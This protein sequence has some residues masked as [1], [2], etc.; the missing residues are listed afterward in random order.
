MATRSIISIKNEDETYD[1]VYCHFDGYPRGVGDTLN[2]SYLTEE[3]IRDLISGGAMSCLKDE[4]TDCEFYTKRGEELH[5]YKSLSLSDLKKK[6]QDV[7]CEYLYM[8]YKGEWH[9][10]EI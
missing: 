3:K 7:G 6:A 9:C 2:K 4:I 8:F 1:A 5:N 10:E